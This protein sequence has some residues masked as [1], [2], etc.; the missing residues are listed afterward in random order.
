M[1]AFDSEDEQA[2]C[3]QRGTASGQ[4]GTASEM[5][6]MED[7]VVEDCDLCSVSAFGVEG[8]EEVAEYLRMASYRESD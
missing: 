2:V 4:R 8:D 7:D 6:G 1:A 3:G 5:Q